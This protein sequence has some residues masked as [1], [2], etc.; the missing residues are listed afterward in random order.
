MAAAL[1]YRS[2][3]APNPVDQLEYKLVLPRPP[4]RHF[5]AATLEA[6]PGIFQR[7]HQ[8]EGSVFRAIEFTILT[9]VRPGAAL[10]ARW[11][12]VDT[13]KAMWTIP[14]E[15]MKRRTEAFIVPLVPASMEVLRRQE[16][17]RTNDFIF[18]GAEPGRPLAYNTF[19]NAL[20]KKLGIE[21]VSLH[22]WRSVWRDW[23]GDIADVPRDIAEAQLSHS[24]GAT[25]ASYRRLTAIEKRRAVLEM[26]SRWLAGETAT[27]IPF[28]ERGVA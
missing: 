10:Y 28:P 21:G 14:A 20:R 4:I 27:V 16:A 7:I 18:P 13:D 2:R 23:A 1:D 6:A 24:L 9:T 5:P 12:E 3:L 15:R 25:E 8:A 11:E 22:G 19:Q 26:Y 17:V